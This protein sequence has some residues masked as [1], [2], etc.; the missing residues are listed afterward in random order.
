MY[1]D[2]DY[3]YGSP[4]ITA[5][6]WEAGRQMSVNTVAV[7]MA[8]HC[9]AGR[10]RPRRRSLTRQG[11]RRAAPDRLGRTFTADHVDQAWCGDVTFIGTAQGPMYLL[12]GVPL[13]GRPFGAENG[14]WPS[15]DVVLLWSCEAVY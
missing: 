8:E 2:S 14:A 12:A 10:E 5:D 13:V 15:G 7:I 1:R 3:T 11:K 6:L 9:W 4:R